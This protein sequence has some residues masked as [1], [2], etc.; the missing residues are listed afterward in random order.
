MVMMMV[1]VV[2]L[3]WQIE[4]WGTAIAV[5]QNLPLCVTGWGHAPAVP[6]LRLLLLLVASLV[7]VGDILRVWPPALSW[8]L[9]LTVVRAWRD[10]WYRTGAPHCIAMPRGHVSLLQ[11]RADTLVLHIHHGAL[12]WGKPLVVL[13]IGTALSVVALPPPVFVPVRRAAF[14]LPVGQGPISIP[15]RR[16]LATCGASTIHTCLG[17]GDL[18]STLAFAGPPERAAGVATAKP[19]FLLFYDVQGGVDAVLE[20]HPPPLLLK[21]LAGRRL[22]GGVEDLGAL[23]VIG[24]GEGGR[25][26]RTLGG[27]GLVRAIAEVLGRGQA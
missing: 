23:L 14:P 25:V 1:V 5:A 27:H 11:E 18:A 3:T 17:A 10:R 8:E 9:H 13:V 19:I 12:L 22:Q 4:L 24:R 15:P 16:G 21:H 20:L 2:L 6:M 26:V 7:L